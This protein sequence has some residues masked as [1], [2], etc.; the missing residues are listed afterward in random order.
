[1]NK[2]FC[3]S[4]SLP[5]PPEPYQSQIQGVLQGYGSRA[6]LKEE[7]F[8]VSVGFF[9]CFHSMDVQVETLMEQQVRKAVSQKHRQHW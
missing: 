6:G 4:Q 5:G 8:E 7:S 9:Y 3:F 1:M 2:D